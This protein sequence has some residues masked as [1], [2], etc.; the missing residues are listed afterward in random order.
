MRQAPQKGGVSAVLSHRAHNVVDDDPLTALYRALDY[1]PTPPWAA[2]ALAELVL[3]IDPRARS[4]WEP[5]CGEGH[6]AHG[7]A[8]YFARVEMSDIHPHGA[9]RVLDFLSP[10]AAPEGEPV[11]WIVTNPPFLHAEAF[12]RL[13]RARARRGVAVLVRIAFLETVGRYGLFT[14]PDAPILVCP[15]AERV[16]MHL[17]RYVAKGS[18]AAG[19]AVIIWACSEIAEDYPGEPV[20]R[21]IEPGCRKRLSRPSDLAFARAA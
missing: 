15:F 11:D 17:G 19:Y 9:G 8:D 10:G 12:V 18:S 20:L 6:M 4:V 21:P 3:R 5:A 2:R 14:G 16:P 1:F 7:L 13:A